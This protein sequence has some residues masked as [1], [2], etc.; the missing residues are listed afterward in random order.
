L[1][2]LASSKTT[3]QLGLSQRVKVASH[4]CEPQ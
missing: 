3:P 1:L 4:L 2:M